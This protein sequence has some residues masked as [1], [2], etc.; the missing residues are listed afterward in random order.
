[1]DTSELDLIPGI[2]AG[3]RRALLKYFGSLKSAKEADIDEL[4][5][6]PGISRK[7]AEDIYKYLHS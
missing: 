4:S 1:M 6:V 2:G 3:R 5:R 7:I